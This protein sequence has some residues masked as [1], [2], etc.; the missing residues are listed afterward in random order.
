[1]FERFKTR[2]GFKIFRLERMKKKILIIKLSSLGDIIHTF[3]AVSDAQKNNPDYEFDWLVDS[4]FQDV[5]KLHPDV[6]NII[7]IPLR[8]WSKNKLSFSKFLNF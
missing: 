6:K 2:T 4:S 5:P 1:M 3:P 7:N 8:A